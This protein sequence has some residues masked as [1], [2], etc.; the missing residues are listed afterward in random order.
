MK[1]KFWLSSTRPIFHTF[2]TLSDISCSAW[3]LSI[4]LHNILWL[5]LSRDVRVQIF[6]LKHIV[7]YTLSR[8]SGWLYHRYLKGMCLNRSLS[9]SLHQKN[10]WP[11]SAVFMRVNFSQCG[12]LFYTGWHF[13]YKKM[14]RCCQKSILLKLFIFKKCMCIGKGFWGQYVNWSLMCSG[15]SG[16]SRK[17]YTS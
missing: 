15:R 17:T 13:N 12:L 6:Y 4:S 8:M 7:G 16:R 1:G 5:S 11:G 3:A 9:L 14:W 2:C 10:T